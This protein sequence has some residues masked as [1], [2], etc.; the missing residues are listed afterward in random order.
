MINM[1]TV[2]DAAADAVAAAQACGAGAADTGVATA[3]AVGSVSAPALQAAI[4]SPD[5]WP[6]ALMAALS[7]AHSMLPLH[8]L[9]VSADAGAPNSATGLSHAALG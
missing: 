2:T 4:K 7:A 8:S 1:G 9:A 5:F 3:G 6:A